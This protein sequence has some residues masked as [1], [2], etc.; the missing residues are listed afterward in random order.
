MVA[1]KY[2]SSILICTEYTVHCPSIPLGSGKS[3]RKSTSASWCV[4]KITEKVLVQVGMYE[5]LTNHMWDGT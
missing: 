5:K 2:Q 4:R 1:R 3:K